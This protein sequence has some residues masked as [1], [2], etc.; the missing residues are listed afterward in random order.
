MNVKWSHDAVFLEAPE[1]EK[2]RNAGKLG[3][4][5]LAL[6]YANLINQIDGLVSAWPF[7]ILCGC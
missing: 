7:T 1:A 4:S 2:K 5:G 6:H 3:S